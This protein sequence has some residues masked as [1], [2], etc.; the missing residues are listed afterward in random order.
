MLI[1]E[2]DTALVLAFFD[3]CV[4]L[5][6]LS[7]QVV[8]TMIADLKTLLVAAVSIGDTHFVFRL[9]M[10]ADDSSQIERQGVYITREQRTVLLMQRLHARVH[11]Y[12]ILRHTGRQ[13]MTVAIE[14]VTACGGNRLVGGHLFFC[15]LEPFVPF[16]GLDID[17]LTEHRH[18]TQRNHDE[19]DRETPY[20][21]S[22]FVA[23]CL[24][25]LVGG[26]V[27]S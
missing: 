9:R 13:Q 8:D 12:I 1:F 6:G 4:L 23:H 21:I 16:D 7:L 24:V 25:I 11:I 2:E 20:G 5:Q 22:L 18:K 17:D 15:H 14:D 26:T 19:D 3:E 27:F 10:V